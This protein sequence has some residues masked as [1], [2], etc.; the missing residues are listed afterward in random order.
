MISAVQVDDEFA[1]HG[2]L[3]KSEQRLGIEIG[4]FGCAD[5]AFW[6]QNNKLCIHVGAGD[7][8]ED[9]DLNIVCGRDIWIDYDYADELAVMKM[10][11]LCALMRWSQLRPSRAAFLDRKNHLRV[12]TPEQVGWKDMTPDGYDHLKEQK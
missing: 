5:H 12:L 4:Y 8:I 9:I 2:I 6:E 3:S 7:Q 1:S 10:Q 11:D